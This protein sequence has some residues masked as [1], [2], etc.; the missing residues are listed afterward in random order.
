MRPGEIHD[1]EADKKAGRL[2]TI[3]FTTQ[4]K[5]EIEED[6]ERSQSPNISIVEKDGS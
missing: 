4:S 5:E 6:I 3:A 2:T 1:K